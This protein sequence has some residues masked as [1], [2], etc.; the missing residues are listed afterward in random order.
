MIDSAIPEKFALPPL[1]SVTG[2]DPETSVLDLFRV[3]AAKVVSEAVS[4][5]LDKALSG[6]DIGEFLWTVCIRVVRGWKADGS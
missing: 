5:D 2:A 1:P 3:A 6:L 4:V